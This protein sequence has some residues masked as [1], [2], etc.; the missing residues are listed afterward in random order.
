MSNDAADVSP[1]ISKKF[2]DKRAVAES[3]DDLENNIVA[4]DETTTEFC[5]DSLINKVDPKQGLSQQDVDILMRRYGPNTLPVPPLPG[6]FQLFLRQF[7]SP[8]IYILLIASL[9]SFLLNQIPNGIFILIV[10][11]INAIIGT[12]QEYS[13]QQSAAALRN[14]VKGKARVRRNGQDLWVDVETL[15]PGDIVLLE[16]GDK[17][18]ADIALFS[19]ANF[20]VDES[21]LT[22]ESVAI[23]KLA[24]GNK[25]T[26]TPLAER[27]GV[28]FAGTIVTRGRGRGRVI[29]TALATE[30]GKISHQVSHEEDSEPPLMIRIRRFTYQTAAAIFMGILLLVG[31]MLI[32]GGYDLEGMAMMAIGLAVSTIPEGLPAAL[33]VALSIGMRR[34]AKNNVIIRKLIAVEALGSC[35][36]IC[37]DKTGTLTVNELTVKKVLLPGKTEGIPIEIG[38]EGIAPG[39]IQ[40]N[41]SSAAL[42]TGLEQL[43]VSAILANE[44]ELDYHSSNWSASGD[45]VDV[46]FLVLAVKAGMSI[47][48]VRNIHR[49]KRLIPY[50]SERAFS[51]SLNCFEDDG[52]DCFH[53]KGSPE[54]ILSM[55][56]TMNVL[57]ECVPLDRALLEAQY[58][59]SARN[60]Y[61]ILAVAR[62]IT[63]AKD[64]VIKS[65]LT[66]EPDCQSDADGLDDQLVDM[67]FMGMVAMID[68]VRPEAKAAVSQCRSG[69]IEVAMVTGDHPVTAKAIA[70]ELG[71]CQQEDPVVTGS[72]IHLAN[73]QA[74]NL[75][76][77][78]IRPCRVFAR[79]EPQQKQQIVETLMRQGHFVAVTGDGVNDAPAMRQ[80]HVGVAMGK[81]GT[82]V[83]KETAQLI[84]TD[85]NFAS[86]V[87]GIEQG[88]IVYNNIRKV[89]GL[90]IATGFSALLL[91][92]LTVT[93][94]LPMPL[95]ALQLLWLNLVANGL[96]DVA[97]AFEPGEGG[98]LDKRPRRPSEPIFERHIIEHILIAG[99]AMGILAF[100]VF[101]F[102]NYSGYGI[103][104]ARNLTL[105]LMVFF[106]NLHAL[107]SR[108]E[109][110][111]L[112]KIPLKSNVFL[113]C[114][115][116]IAQGLHILAM[117]TPGLR[118]VLSLE[119]ISLQQWFALFGV[120]CMFLLVE[121]LHKA[122]GRSRMR[123]A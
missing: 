15:V 87:K 117:Y 51:G 20:S 88:R 68:P 48:T 61:R 78:L 97:L 92:F 111:S 121:E 120:A 66:H 93:A 41:E 119:P 73:Q 43:C 90:L 98:E 109:H 74:D 60:G 100:S 21:M 40:W 118:E 81:R 64:T 58:E 23:T 65:E 49:Q 86:I 25:D 104:S 101:S 42:Q 113:A 76:A 17:V 123:L 63:N 115:V 22:G 57:G 82:D 9:L 38:G 13:A 24:E 36:F 39:E 28:C 95:T 99:G 114:A 11:A 16:S 112:F 69:G 116:P 94:G 47:E 71:L 62:K 102:L 106:G 18:P 105:F 91:F 84:I 80:S 4:E 12:V 108:S 59:A 50:E 122:Y 110:R 26:N 29:A 33:T 34:M 89:I 37:S 103:D 14:L 5:C 2:I 32:R 85:D 55:C 8:F 19:V 72:D 77:E 35:T 67:E 96:Q 83:A 75:A 70:L 79:I 44:S 46:A 31:M 27:N 6:L 52:R 3:S 56:T 45:I 30:L 10:L 53:V 107:S 7:L 1:A 54:K